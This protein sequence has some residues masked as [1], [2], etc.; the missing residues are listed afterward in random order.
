MP[1]RR[2]S[3]LL[4]DALFLALLLLG[5]FALADSSITILPAEVSLHGPESFQRLLVQRVEGEEGRVQVR[6][7]V[8]L[9]SSGPT[10]VAVDGD[11]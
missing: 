10:I 7:G 9:T 11:T 8:E 3:V 2:N 1:L 5:N 6:E 4:T